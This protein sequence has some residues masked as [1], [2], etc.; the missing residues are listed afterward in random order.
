MMR[1]YKANPMKQTSNFSSFE[2]MPKENS[3]AVSDDAEQVVPD[4][5]ATEEVMNIK[6]DLPDEKEV[7]QNTESNDEFELPFEERFPPPVIPDFISEVPKPDINNSY[8]NL[9]V[10]VRTGNGG[11]PVK[12]SLVTISEII[13]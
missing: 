2:I 1:I 10:S 7:S 4:V 8:G 12:G 11:R 6:Q 5:N 13:D 9:K 3:A